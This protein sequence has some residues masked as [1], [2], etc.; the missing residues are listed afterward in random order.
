MP[1]D[2]V[3]RDSRNRAAQITC[4]VTRAR[5]NTQAIGTPS[6]EDWIFSDSSRGPRC[7]AG[8]RDA[9]KPRS[10]TPPRAAPIA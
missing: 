2:D 1:P 5:P 7:R 4:P 9:I 3:V 6:A 8:D 10:T